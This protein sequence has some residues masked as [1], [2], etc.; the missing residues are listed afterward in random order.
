MLY[1]IRHRTTYR[2]DQS[3]SL[4]HH[5]A[6]LR[7]IDR[8]GQACHAHRLSV[9]PVPA[10]IEETRDYFGNTVTAFAIAEPHRALVVAAESEVERHA[11]DL[12]PAIGNL[13]WERLAQNL[14]APA[15]PADLVASEFTFASPAARPSDRGEAAIRRYAGR[16]FAPGRSIKAAALDLTR[17]IHRDFAFDSAATSIST[18]PQEVLRLKRGVC[19]DFAH[20]TIACCRSFGLAA[21]YV[22]GYL[23]TRPPSGAE[24]LIGADASH[25]WVSIYAGEGDWLELDPTNDQL[26]GSNHLALAIGRDFRDV[27][28]LSGVI[29][30]GGTHDVTVAVDVERLLI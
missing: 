21:R 11:G 19:Q 9:E 25:A 16:S 7:P 22:S 27:S 3:V 14:A 2:Y 10:S 5:A 18:P 6:Y 12:D 20:L 1:R 17:R 29:L 8:P 13:S 26:A 30:G 24:R 4:S 28:P 23:E 15:E